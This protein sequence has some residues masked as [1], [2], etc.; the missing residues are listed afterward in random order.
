MT[1]TAERT[2]SLTV[3]TLSDTEIEMSRQVDAPAALVFEAWTRPE[4]VPHWMLGPDGWTMPTCEI[5][6]RP[7]GTWRFVWRK[8]DGKEMEMTGTY[9][10]VSPPTRLV[11]TESWGGEWPE[12]VN[13]LTLT[14]EDGRTTIRER[15][16]YVSR[17]VRDRALATGM[18]DGA[19]T[20]FDRLDTL[21]RALS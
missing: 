1:T 5:D 18:A 8:E 16:R 7:G 2:R 10:E 17:E 3:T 11:T 15:I 13:T 14:E 19:A 9:Q 12:S 4:H 21:L 6:L 20:S